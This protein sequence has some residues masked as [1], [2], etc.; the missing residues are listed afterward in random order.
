MKKAVFVALMV[1][2]SLTGCLVKK[3]TYELEL[4]EHAKTKAALS[5][6]TDKQA[7]SQGDLERK[8]KN[9]TEVFGELAEAQLQ[10]SKSRLSLSK[11]RS[12]LSMAE[13]EMAALK[14]EIEKSGVVSAELAKKLEAAERRVAEAKDLFVARFEELKEKA[15]AE[16]AAAN[17][18]NMKLRTFMLA[19]F[20]KAT[21]HTTAE[22]PASVVVEKAAEVAAPS[23]PAE[24]IEKAAPIEAPETVEVEVYESDAKKGGWWKFWG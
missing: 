21:F 12:A 17:A 22:E 2:I 20:P 1:S 5:E 8:E 3:S 16:L 11:S 7:V 10:L 6:M 13:Q 24:T 23:A 4:A 18:E 15:E 14:A 19:N 9:L